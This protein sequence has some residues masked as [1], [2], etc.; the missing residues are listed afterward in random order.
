MS[1]EIKV[2]LKDGTIVEFDKFVVEV[3][4]SKVEKFD[5]YE[6]AEKY[7]LRLDQDN[8]RSFMKSQGA[9]VNYNNSSQMK[10]IN[11]FIYWYANLGPFDKTDFINLIKKVVKVFD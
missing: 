9:F 6:K 7:I 2:Q 8:L 5:D 11:I 10:L 3:S 1:N 4:S